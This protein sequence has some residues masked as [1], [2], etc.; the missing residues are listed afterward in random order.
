MEGLQFQ[1][2]KKPST[3]ALQKRKNEA[4]PPVS[5]FEV[6]CAADEQ[7]NPAIVLAEELMRKDITGGM[8][9]CDIE[10]T[11]KTLRLA[12]DEIEKVE[13]HFAQIVK[14]PPYPSGHIPAGF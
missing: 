3:K 7:I 10:Q 4:P 1:S 6:L 14:T 8:D 5:P 12:R 11:E 9:F 13:R 2:S